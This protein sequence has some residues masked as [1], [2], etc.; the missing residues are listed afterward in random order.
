MWQM[1][2]TP[3]T[4][5]ASVPSH[6]VP[7]THAVRRTP[8]TR[9]TLRTL[10]C[11]AAVAALLLAAAAHAQTGPS[12]APRPVQASALAQIRTL[13]QEKRSRTPAQRKID[14]N[15]LYALLRRRQDPRLAA[16]P[17][18]RVAVPDADGTL[19]VDIR[20]ASAAAV[21]TIAGA[22]RT[23]GGR[24]VAVQPRLLRLRA[25]LPLAALETLAAMP[26]VRQVRRAARAVFDHVDSEGD[27]TH[28]AA[29]ARTFFGADGTGSKICA[30]S[31]G[32]DSL[33]ELQAMG[34]LPPGVDVLPGQAGSGD[35]GTAMLEIL[36]DLAPGAR[37]GFASANPDEA[38]FAQ[39]ILDLRNTA[40]CD[41]LVDDVIYPD[42]SPFQDTLVAQAVNTVT[43]AGAL[44]FSSAGNEGSLDAGTSG[45]WEGDFKA[46][47]NL[48][49]VL[50]TGAGA[51]HDFGDG[52]QADPVTGSGQFL[53]LLWADPFGASCNDYDL[54]LLDSA[55]ANVEG[56]STN[57]QDCT[58]DPDEFIDGPIPAGDQVVIT[59]FSGAIRVLNVIDFRGQLQLATSGATR[60]HSAADGA[61]S[62]AAAPAAAP[63]IPGDPSGPFPNPFTAAQLTEPFSSDGPRRIFFDNAGHLLPGAPPGNFT[64]SGGVLRQKPD[65][66]AAD[67]V[68]VDVPGFSP[69]FGTSA[70]APHAAAIAA[71]V[72]SAV[73]G[74][75]PGQVRAALTGSAIDVL[76]AGPDRD[77][78]AGIVMAFQAL[79][80]A[81]ARPQALLALGAV[82]PSQLAG[83]GDG[84]IDPGESW[85]LAISLLDIGG[86]T[87][88]GVSATLATS[89][90]G[91]IVTGGA[92]AY[93]DLLQGVAGANLVPFTFTV[94]GGACGEV[95]Q[96]TLTVAYAGGAGS[97]TFSF[98]LRTGHA[99]APVTVSYTGPVV[100]IPDAVFRPDGSIQPN[101]AAASLVVGGLQGRIAKLV[102][103]I[104]GT[105]CTTAP[106]A[107]TV[108]VDHTFIND[109]TFQL[110]SPSGTVVTVIDEI[111]FDGHNLC[112]VTLDDDSAGPSIQTA[113]SAQAPF[114]GS[115]KPATPLAAFQGEDPNGTWQLVGT[116]NAPFDTG[117]MRAFSLIITPAACAAVTAAEVPALSATGSAAMALA[118]AAGALAVLRRR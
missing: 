18:L 105:A 3:C 94:G 111:D 37:L 66:T 110:V 90:P 116:D 40:G 104:D 69:F 73:P 54:Y 47:G 79:Q 6:Q 78:G 52:G 51:A 12:A 107:T 32:V 84:A 83:N 80:A 33:A 88:Q 77:S 117:S 63:F 26:E 114:T 109:L 41:I 86:A 55:L 11:A 61:F 39:N 93:G 8:I 118:L 89:T 19:P 102:L 13:A 59:L 98:T 58:Q 43:A 115:W 72:R 29:Q 34:D 76:A 45:T 38:S 20:A 97:Q 103:R 44:Y 1:T 10:P 99:A 87:A 9:R 108:G 42:E 68:A 22:M 65:L 85:A 75:S 113:V 53:A 62:V 91:V 15:L 74:I 30:L 64:A 49:P 35:E 81:G 31:D 82:T 25:R 57:T 56:A 96:F 46:N 28:L 112:Q 2:L 92:S 36:H 95:L 27:A 4:P 21:A 70:A 50:G 60:G 23:L 106:G 17:R 5:F 67:G 101:S 7:S 16:V 14:S 48:D 71:L 100:P 24:L